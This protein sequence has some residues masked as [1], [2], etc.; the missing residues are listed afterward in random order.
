MNPVNFGIY[1]RRDVRESNYRLHSEPVKL[2][3]KITPVF[4]APGVDTWEGEGGACAPLPYEEDAEKR[5]KQQMNLRGARK[6]RAAKQFIPR[7]SIKI[8]QIKTVVPKEVAMAIVEG[9]SDQEI[10][11]ARLTAKIQELMGVINKPKIEAA[12]KIESIKKLEAVFASKRL[13]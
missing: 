13:K 10:E 5:Y 8:V 9:K 11:V 3:A 12:R 2:T 6:Q 1:T 4:D 7:E